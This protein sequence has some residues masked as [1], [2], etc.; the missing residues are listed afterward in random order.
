MS[1]L[2][3]AFAVL[4]ASIDLLAA[5]RFE[6]HPCS[7]SLNAPKIVCGAV[8]VPETPGGPRTIALAVVIV[9][10]LQPTADAP[11]LFHLE[12][13]PGISAIGS[14]EFYAGPGSAY[15]KTR[16]VVLVDA[17]GSGQ[18]N[19]LRCDELEKR[20]PLED[21]YDDAIVDACRQRLEAKADLTSYS[22]ERTAA[23]IDAVRAALGYGRIDLWALSYGTR[24]AQEYMKRFPAR[25]AHAV[26]VGF[27]PLDY[28]APLY[29]AAIAQ[30]TL[31]L[32]FYKCQ[33]DVDCSATYPHLRAEWQAVLDKLSD[34]GKI[35]RGPFV[36]SIRASM[37][38]AAG[39]RRLPSIIHAAAAGDFDP[40]LQS[41]PKD[42]SQFAEGLYL[43]IVCSEAVARI[44]PQSIQRATEGTFV[45]AYRVRQEMAACAKWP[46]FTP[47]ADFFD[48]PKNAI[49]TL[50]ISGEMD[51]VTAPEWAEE[52]C[53]GL[54]KCRLVKIADLGHGPFDLEAWTNGDCF[55]SIIVSFYGSANSP[56]LSCLKAMRPPKFR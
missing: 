25:V 37:G 34:E 33:R 6:N 9:R 56:D 3:R 49:P 53:A 51:N 12:G 28:R 15:R 11:P 16:D 20:S 32:L 40:Y 43:S 5:P 46:K 45:G 14:A 8:R 44:D 47:R 50:I 30:R 19:P 26:L 36:E 10:A 38:T 21:M 41:L 39:Q 31:D 55:D 13:G 2:L 35:R 23:D 18:S 4:A 1:R 48:P 42:S 54:P 24:L 7:A 27:A 52:F 17:R 29:H 22:T